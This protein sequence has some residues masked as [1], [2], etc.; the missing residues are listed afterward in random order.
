M[1]KDFR[2]HLA[3]ATSLQLVKDPKK[4]SVVGQAEMA[5]QAIGQ[6]AAGRPVL[7]G[8]HRASRRPPVRHAGLN[9]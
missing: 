3:I 8:E 2:K 1:D 4:H 5:S 6:I 9:E 7:P